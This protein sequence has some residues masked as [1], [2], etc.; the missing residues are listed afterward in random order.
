[1]PDKVSQ[2]SERKKK[3]WVCVIVLVVFH[4]TVLLGNK[5]IGFTPTDK[6]AMDIIRELDTNVI[7]QCYLNMQRQLLYV[8]QLSFFCNFLIHLNSECLIYPT[9][10]KK[11]RKSG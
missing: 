4:S 3:P 11:F 8:K 9:S 6:E 5:G 7:I 10:C 1:M 2:L